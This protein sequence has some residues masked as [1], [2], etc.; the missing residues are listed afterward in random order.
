MHILKDFG[1]PAD[2]EA[3]QPLLELVSCDAQIPYNPRILEEDD[4]YNFYLKAI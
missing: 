3:L 2:R 1:V 4:I